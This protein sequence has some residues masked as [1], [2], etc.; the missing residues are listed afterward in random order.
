[1]IL[2][3]DAD[4]KILRSVFESINWMVDSCDLSYGVQKISEACDAFLVC[5]DNEMRDMAV[6]VVRYLKNNYSSAVVV[7]DEMYDKFF[8]RKVQSVGV[9]MYLSNPIDARNVCKYVVFSSIK[10]DLT[11]SKV[12]T[13]KDL[14]L[15]MGRR[16]VCRGEKC[17]ELRNK[18]F[19]LLK[20][21]LQNPGIVL[22]KTKILEAVWDMNAFT[23]TTTVESHVSTL[24]SKLDK[25]FEE[26][27]LHTVHCVGY[28]IE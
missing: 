22:S 27:L 6:G 8:E 7:L 15:D 10:Y 19:D 1:M 4:A 13:Y 12:I 17:I 18:E 25:G 9:D 26:R 5:V 11:E 21:L 23:N 24:R 28:K 20:Y 16:T 14:V 3:F 2:H